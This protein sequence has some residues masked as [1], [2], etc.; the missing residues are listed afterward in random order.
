MRDHNGMTR[1]DRAV[2]RVAWWMFWTVIGG[3]CS[4]LKIYYMSRLTLPLTN[5]NE[6][7]SLDCP[8][9]RSNLE[10]ESQSSL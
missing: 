5:T 6:A 7:S 4:V 8:P 3:T 2:G 10:V 1:F 9:S